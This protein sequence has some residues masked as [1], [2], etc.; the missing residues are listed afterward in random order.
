MHMHRECA[1]KEEEEEKKRGASAALGF[2]FD[3]SDAQSI[4]K[5]QSLGRSTINALH[6][7][8]LHRTFSAVNDIC[9]RK[10]QAKE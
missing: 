9:A 5:S 6:R 10:S 7:T 4:C 8:A 3:V 1:K 2:G